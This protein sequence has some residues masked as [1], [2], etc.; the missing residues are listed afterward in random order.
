M[1]LHFEPNAVYE[2]HTLEGRKKERY[3]SPISLKQTNL[4]AYVM[5]LV[6]AL[7]E[8]YK[9]VSVFDLK[10]KSNLNLRTDTIFRFQMTSSRKFEGIT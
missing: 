6:E 4:P 3:N 7:V 8:L 10:R 5:H 2:C 1:A 9:A